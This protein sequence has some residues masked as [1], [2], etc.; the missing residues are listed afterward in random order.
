[1]LKHMVD[2]FSPSDKLK[3]SNRYALCKL[4]LCL[5]IMLLASC[6]KHYDDPAV[7][8]SE[9]VYAFVDADVRKAQSLTVLEQW[10]RIEEQM[11]GREPFKCR[12]GEWD[13]TGTSGTCYHAADNERDCGLV[14]QCASERTPYCLLVNDILV[15]ETEN[16]WKVYD[17]G[18]ICEAFNH[19][20]RCE[21]LCGN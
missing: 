8:A 6:T 14:Y 3:G 13:T 1:M 9:L 20:Y 2:D 21:E 4:T 5:Y 19:S 15:R 7:V 11:E 12:E 18:S 10:D 16:G 17:W